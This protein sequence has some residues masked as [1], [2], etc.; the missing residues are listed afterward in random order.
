MILGLTTKKRHNSVVSTLKDQHSSE[1]TKMKVNLT[2]KIDIAHNDISE[3]ELKVKQLEQENHALKDDLEK[4]NETLLTLE[5]K[6]IGKELE[7]ASVKTTIEKLTGDN[8]VSIYFD[9]ELQT[10]TPKVTFNED[11]RIFLIENYVIQQQSNK[12]QENYAI[13]LALMADA[14]DGLDNLL[15]K[16]TPEVK[17]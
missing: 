14:R 16:F 12:D 3:L 9:D 17:E 7:L 13:Q 8:C 10:I 11:M 6:V 1:F 15:E 2:N 4:N 5:E